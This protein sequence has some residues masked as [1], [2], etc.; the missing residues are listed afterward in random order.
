MTA[1][2][3]YMIASW[4]DEEYK[5]LWFGKITNTF[6]QEYILKEDCKFESFVWAINQHIAAVSGEKSSKIVAYGAG[7]MAK[8]YLPIMKG[9]VKFCE[10]WDAYT[11]ETCMEELTIVRP[12]ASEEK[13]TIIVFIDDYF[14]RTSVNKTLEQLGYADVYYFRDYMQIIKDA[15][16]LKD[17]GKY[18]TN[19]TIYVLKELYDSYE[20]IGCP[21]DKVMYAILEKKASHD[22][23]GIYSNCEGDAQTLLDALSGKLIFDECKKTVVYDC[24]ENFLR[25]DFSDGYTFAYELEI[26]LRN[27]LKD[28]VKTKERPMRMRNDQPYDRFSVA[29]ALV[30]IIKF[31]CNGKMDS[32]LKAIQFLRK[33]SLYYIPLMAVECYFLVENELYDEALKLARKAIHKESNDLL[34][35]ETFYQVALACKKAGINVEEPIPEYDLSEKFC[36]CGMTFAWCGGFDS[37][38]E[39]AD[40]S[41]CFRPLQ[42]AAHPEGEFWI[43]E[44]WIEFRK[45]LIDGS[46]RYCQKNQCSNLVSGWL[47]EKKN[48]KDPVI[49][50]ILNGNFSK[51]PELEELHFSYDGHCNLMC[52]SCRLDIQTMTS[53][54]AEELDSLYNR[55]LKPYVK[56]AKHLCLSGCGEAMIS[57][58]SKKILQSFNQEEYPQLKVELRTNATTVNAN[59][60]EKLGEGRKCIRHIA[61]SIDAAKKETFEKLRYP[62]KWDLVYENLK[63]IQSLRN[64]NQIDMFEFHVV[65][66]QDNVDELLDIVKMAIDLDADAVTFSRMINWREIPEEEYDCTNPFW[67]SSPYHQALLDE[68]RKIEELRDDIENGRCKLLKGDKK[69]YINIHFVPDPNETY[70]PIRYGDLKIR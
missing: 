29:E 60:W 25:C 55:C 16:C 30:Q 19:E 67:I 38:K 43:G 66:Q 70:A 51:A 69:F 12:Y 28:R 15:E 68:L 53:K 13:I 9:Q 3:L 32:E 4:L 40:F 58:H 62:A 20:M 61:V 63:F 45:S 36:W 27:I 41:P 11:K 22:E 65:V 52:P 18:V 26:L 23:K 10:I 54:Q 64:S 50:D 33:Q 21:C 14:I 46:F 17:I 57:P 59:S 49:L 31:I 42:C 47:P 8:K 34:A 2:E 24:L 37:E 39:V 5:K 56:N 44:D 1:S 35:N 6:S 48:C 7:N